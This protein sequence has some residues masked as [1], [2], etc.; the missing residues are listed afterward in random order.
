MISIN[1]IDLH[2]RK[3]QIGRSNEA[4]L[5]AVDSSISPVELPLP[6]PISASVRSGV[7][8]CSENDFRCND[9]KCIRFE[10]KCDGSGDCSDGEDEKDCPHPGCKSDQWQCDKYEW[11]SVSCIPEYQRCDNITDCADGSDEVDCPGMSVS[12]TVNDGSVFQC[13]DG[14]QC[15]DISK[16]CDGK[17]DCRDLSDEK[18]SCPHNHTACFQ[19]QFR[20][21]DQSQCIQKS[22]VCDGSNDCADGSDE[23]STCEFKQCSSGEFQCKNKRC[24]PRKFRCDYYDDCGDNSDEEGCGQYL[25]PPQQWNCPGSGHC[26]H[27][28]KLCDGKNDCSDGADE[29]NCSSNLCP[30]LGC[31]AGCHSSPS[32]GVCTCPVGYKLDE[33]FHRTCSDINECVEWGYCDQGC[34]NHRPGFACSCLSECYHLEMMHGPS[35]DNHTLRGYC[36]SRDSETMRLYIAR[37]EGLYRINPNNPNEEAKK[38]VTGEF[39]YG[40]GFDFGDKKMFWTDRLSHSAFSGDIDDDG[41]IKNIKKLDL[42][43]LI[44]PRNLAVD[45]IT[46]HLYIV[47]SG[48]KR[49][50]ISTFDGERRTV[51]IAD[52]LI[53]PLDIA[54]DPIRGEMFFSNQFKLEGAAMDGTQRYTLIDTHT[55][56]V[57]GVVVDIAAK[58]VYWVDPKVDRVESIDYN[59]NDRRVVVQGMNSVPHPF[60]LTIFDQYLY[61]TDWTRLGVMRVEKFGSSTDIIWTK[62]ENN[63]FPMGIAAYHPMTQIGPQES[64]CLGLKVD[65]PCVEADCQGMCILTKDT[66]GVGVGYRCVCPIGQ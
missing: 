63:V 27:K 16:K 60:G 20:C 30:S 37:R 11:R 13:A 24:Q 4:V 34:Q 48:S 8:S 28:T 21:A 49:I 5:I 33:R 62:K 7:I 41:D 19:H 52:D 44:F 14:R 1:V 59:G 46:N 42:K 15:F 40:I 65:N 56:Q 25:C 45:W 32:G 17:Y 51:L 35:S 29:K 6:G 54:L 3:V 47:E 18:D 10:W 66:N 55:H 38:L 61:W 9:G 50:D 23:P 36:L 53:L 64:E 57:S 2:I 22:W 12:C 31:Q 39:I 43:N 26:I 58:R